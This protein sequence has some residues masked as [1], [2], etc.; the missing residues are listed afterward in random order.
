MTTYDPTAERAEIRRRILQSIEDSRRDYWRALHSVEDHCFDWRGVRFFVDQSRPAI[1]TE[2]QVSGQWAYQNG[3]TAVGNQGIM[4][5]YTGSSRYLDARRFVSILVEMLTEY[6]LTVLP[7]TPLCLFFNVMAAESLGNPVKE[8]VVWLGA[9]RALAQGR[10]SENLCR[11]V[12]WEP[13]PG[14][15]PEGAEMPDVSSPLSRHITD[16]EIASLRRQQPSLLEAAVMS[17]G[18]QDVVDTG[19]ALKA[20]IDRYVFARVQH[21]LHRDSE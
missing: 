10:D 15:V 1:A 19:D 6:P 4:R 3:R 16:D 7:E 13:G 2:M 5:P 14:V 9:A 8:M 20:Y 17:G 11:L 12:P 21:D 18:D